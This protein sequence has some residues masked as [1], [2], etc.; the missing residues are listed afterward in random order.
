ML[1]I[2]RRDESMIE[3]ED[4]FFCHRVESKVLVKKWLVDVADRNERRKSIKRLIS[5]GKQREIA[6][7]VGE[8]SIEIVN[9]WSF[10]D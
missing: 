3:F 2:P 5:D 10:V 6:K 4:S 8:N 9:H 7:L 1:R